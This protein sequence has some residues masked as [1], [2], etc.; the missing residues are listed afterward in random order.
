MVKVKG[1]MGQGQLKGHNIGRW[2]HANVK[3]HF[4]YICPDGV[5]A[6]PVGGGGTQGL[7]LGGP[8]LAEVIL[9]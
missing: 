9:A 8:S 7:L 1:H 4:F 6:R 3:L 2:A 5:S